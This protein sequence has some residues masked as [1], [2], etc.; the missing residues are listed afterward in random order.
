MGQGAHQRSER[1]EIPERWGRTRCTRDPSA[2]K[3]L[4]DGARRFLPEIRALRNPRTMGQGACCQ[5]SERSE[6][7]ER[8]GKACPVKDPSAQKS[9]NDGA[10]MLSQ[11][12]EHHLT[13][14]H[15]HLCNR[16]N[17]HATGE[18]R[19]SRKSQTTPRDCP[20]DGQALG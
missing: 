1:S 14:A 17:S 5:R 11:R 4:N 6:I 8:W 19:S 20:N 16:C 18:A 15:L 3:C 2:Q 12:S 9:P 13:N 10:M 7:P